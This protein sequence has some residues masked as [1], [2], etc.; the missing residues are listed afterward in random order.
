MVGCPRR[1]AGWLKNLRFQ[2]GMCGGSCW[3]GHVYSFNDMAVDFVTVASS[4]ARQY[5]FCGPDRRVL[6]K[7][8]LSTQKTYFTR[9]IYT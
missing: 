3:I 9:R 1:P 7:M 8:F 5:G 4:T 6:T 2:M